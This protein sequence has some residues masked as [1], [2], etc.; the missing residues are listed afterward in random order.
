MAATRGNTPELTL[1]VGKFVLLVS[2]GFAVPVSP[3]KIR[4]CAL[5]DIMMEEE[6]QEEAEAE[7][8]RPARASV[9][10]PGRRGRLR[11]R[12]TKHAREGRYK[13][14]SY[15]VGQMGERGVRFDEVL[16]VL[17][18]RKLRTINEGDRGKFI[19][20]GKMPDGVDVGAVIS[21][22]E[23]KI[24]VLS[25]L[26]NGERW[27]QLP[28]IRRYI[29]EGNYSFAVDAGRSMRS[30]NIDERD[31]LGVLQNGFVHLDSSED[32]YI[33]WGTLPDGREAGFSVA[34]REGTMEIARVVLR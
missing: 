33:V 34:F 32:T 1:V 14:E 2:F 25:V 24:V 15:A 18:G 5:D 3:G 21:L 27:G 13:I 4:N 29:A 31:A 6:R 7:A 26:A 12:V 19:A 10:R 20:W 17:D 8:R 16:S 22:E 23:E 30:K 9:G 11:Y 28:R